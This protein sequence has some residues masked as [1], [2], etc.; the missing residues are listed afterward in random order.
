MRLFF[1][2]SHFEREQEARDLVLARAAIA[3]G[4][5]VLADNPRPN[6]PPIAREKPK[7][8]SPQEPDGGRMRMRMAAERRARVSHERRQLERQHLSIANAHVAKAER[9]IRGQMAILDKL[10]CDGHD[11]RL[12]EDTLRVFEANL[13]VMREHRALIIR[14]IEEAD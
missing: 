6:P 14:A 11:T 9:L 8:P 3:L 10:H 13:Q 5:K 2:L 7:K 4:R 1:R 12:A